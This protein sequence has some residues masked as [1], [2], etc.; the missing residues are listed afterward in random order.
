M[1]ESCYSVLFIEWSTKGRDFEID[2]P[3]MYFFE[4]KLKWKVHYESIFC[5]PRILSVKPDIVI[6][7]NTT[8]ARINN[9][10][11]SFIK[12]SNILFFSHTS[13]GFFRK[14][15]IEEMVFGWNKGK[16]LYENFT[17]YWSRNS[18]LLANEFSSKLSKK[19]VVTGSIGHDKY[20]IYKRKKLLTNNK[21]KKIISYAAMDFHNMFSKTS[22]SDLKKNI[23]YPYV[24]LINNI[25]YELVKE[26]QDI[27]FIIKSHPGDGNKLPQEVEKIKNFENVMFKNNEISIVDL[28]SISDVWLNFRSST[29]LEAWLLNKPTISFCENKRLSYDSE[30]ILGSIQCE[31]IK[32][33]GLYIKEFYKTGKI[34]DFKIKKN[35]REKLIKDLIGFNDG[36]NHIRFMS[37][38]KTYIDKI[39]SNK[40]KKGTWNISLNEKIK[41]YIKHIIYL[42]SKGKYNTPYIKKWAHIYDIFDKKEVEKQK[43][44]R[45]PEFDM[46]Y[47]NNEDKIND[48]YNNNALNWRKELEIE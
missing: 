27:L 14:D 5:I 24:E 32:K 30:F 40:I 44:L 38:C 45:Y 12:E 4:K 41:A 11:A 47:K 42:I 22:F 26:N 1:K 15:A 37:F 6:M 2:L 9:R 7:S 16:N 33:I 25:L 39:E 20:K 43:K 21:Y 28:I 18:Y 46:F 3:L 34:E 10:M 8:G 29:N 35:F 31:N 13:E 23:N 19:S 36:F 17:S 48:I